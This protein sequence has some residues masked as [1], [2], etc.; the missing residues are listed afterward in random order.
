MP[1]RRPGGVDQATFG[2][3]HGEGDRRAGRDRVEAKLVAQA[4]GFEDRGLIADAAQR[5]EREQAL[6]FE[7]NRAAGRLVDVLAADGAGGARLPGDT[8]SGA[9]RF[10]G[11]LLGGVEGSQLKVAGWQRG[12]AVECQQVRDGAKLAVLRRRRAERTLGE[13][14]GGLDDTCGIGDGGIARA[15]DGD[16][17][18]SL[19]A[20]D[21]AEA[22]AAGVAR[23][24]TDGSVANAALTG[25][26]DDRRVE[27]R[28]E[29]VAQP[30]GCFV[31]AQ[32]PQIARRLQT[33]LRAFD[34]QAARLGCGAHDHQRV[35]AGSLG[36]QRKMRRRQCVAQPIRERRLGEHRKL[37][38]SRERRPDQRAQAE[39]DRR[40]GSEWIDAGRTFA[41]HQVSAD[42]DTAEESPQHRFIERQVVRRAGAEV[43]A[44]VAAVVAVHAQPPASADRSRRRLPGSRC[45][46]GSV[47]KRTPS[48]E[49][50]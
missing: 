27:L 46:P 34:H 49:R 21:G 16:R 10:T 3:L 30:I 43:D 35:H 40:F 36:R 28:A 19:G 33:R 48:S 6:V 22:A 15:R 38:G 9:E 31:G 7:P 25:G 41:V 29:A 32:A 12:E 45:S 13:I 23:F 24:V 26:A 47:R 5:A 1:K 17:L 4:G 42:A 37:G 14:S 44:P 11:K 50:R 39:D 2:T 18:E 8:A 20:H